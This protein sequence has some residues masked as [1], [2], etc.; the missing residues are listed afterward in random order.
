MRRVALSRWMLIVRLTAVGRLLL[1]LVPLLVQV[2]VLPSAIPV[3]QNVRK[4]CINRAL[5]LPGKLPMTRST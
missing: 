2:V 3:G 5:T 4:L 1:L